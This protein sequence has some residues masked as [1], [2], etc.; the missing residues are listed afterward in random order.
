VA[1]AIATAAPG[2]GRPGDVVTIAGSGFSP[3]FGQNTVTLNG[4]SA[5]VNSSTTTEIVIVVPGGLPVD[6][7]VPLVVTNLDDAT[8]D[9]TFWWSQDTVANT[10]A[11]IL[12]Q[13]I[14]W[15]DEKLRGLGRTIKNMNT[16]E[17]RFFESPRPPGRAGELL[18]PCS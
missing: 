5:G 3:T 1:V 14:P 17:G 8:S 15:D 2:R 16:A 6:Q 11:L 7:H 10:E 4:I 12:R 9:T 18:Q 13:K